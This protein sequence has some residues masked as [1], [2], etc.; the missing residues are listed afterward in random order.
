MSK[1]WSMSFHNQLY[2]LSLSLS[3]SNTHT[4][5]HTNNVKTLICVYFYYSARVHKTLI[6]FIKTNNT[7]NVYSIYWQKHYLCRQIYRYKK[8]HLKT[9]YGCTIHELLTSKSTKLKQYF[10]ALY[11]LLASSLWF[12]FFL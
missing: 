1:S 10:I 12:H 4:H 9:Y 5:T 8:A 3:L 7:V 2:Y 6:C 11:F